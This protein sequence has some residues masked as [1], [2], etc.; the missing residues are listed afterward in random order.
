[1]INSSKYAAGWLV[2]LS[3]LRCSPDTM[4]TDIP[5]TDGAARDVQTVA[6][7]AMSDDRPDPVRDVVTQMDMGVVTDTP[8]VD[9]RPTP[10]SDTFVPPA[11]AN[12]GAYPAAPYGS[13]MGDTLENLAFQGHLVADGAQLS[14]SQP[15][16]MMLTMQRVRQTGKRY[17]LIHTG[18]FY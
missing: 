5:S 10:P 8:A 16:D 3:L 9:D 4:P 7:D 15:F 14:N 1:M 18:A 2:T 6:M 13:N 17:A 11:D 12:V